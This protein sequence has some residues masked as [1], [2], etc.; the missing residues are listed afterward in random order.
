MSFIEK[1]PYDV[2]FLI[3]NELT[4]T[5]RTDLSTSCTFVLKCESSSSQAEVIVT[6]TLSNLC[7]ISI[8]DKT[9][10]VANQARV[11]REEVQIL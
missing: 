2:I 3:P 5:Y 4:K 8:N 9:D 1:N 11:Q 7:G 10:D 6:I